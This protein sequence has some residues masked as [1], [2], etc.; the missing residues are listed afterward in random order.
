MPWHRHG[1]E[2]MMFSI[3]FVVVSLFQDMVG[4]AMLYPVERLPFVVGQ[5]FL[6]DSAYAR[7]YS[8]IDFLTFM[9]A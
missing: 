7:S 8:K 6:K 9:K 4:I 2:E 3:A 1:K 5:I